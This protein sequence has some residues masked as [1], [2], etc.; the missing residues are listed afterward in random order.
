MAVKRQ[1][2]NIPEQALQVLKMLERAGNKAYFVGQ[3][4]AELLRGGSPMDY[5]IITTADFGEM[6]Y[7]FRDMR[8]VSQNEDMSSVMVSSLG[9]VIQVSSYCG[10]IKDGKAVEEFSNQLSSTTTG[11]SALLNL[12]ASSSSNSVARSRIPLVGS[13]RS[14]FKRSS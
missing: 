13:V 3:C 5:D 12:A 2:L 8:I 7:V 14:C 6:L 10:E 9:L 1:T 11:A 4:V